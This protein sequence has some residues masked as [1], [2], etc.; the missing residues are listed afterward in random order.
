MLG[1]NGGFMRFFTVL[2]VP[3]ALLG[4]LKVGHGHFNVNYNLLG[5]VFLSIDVM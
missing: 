2:V 1:L 5:T 3:W 4:Y